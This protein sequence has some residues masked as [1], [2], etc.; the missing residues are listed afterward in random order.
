M[1]I[2][3]LVSALYLV[4][5]LAMLGS[6]KDDIRDELDRQNETYTPVR[7]RHGVSASSSRRSWSSA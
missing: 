4:I 6:L 7:H 2:G 3:A 1:R 5:T